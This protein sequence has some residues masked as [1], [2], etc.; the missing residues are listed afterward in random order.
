MQL[1]DDM[2]ARRKA[3]ASYLE[4]ARAVGC[5]KSTVHRA[6]ERAGTAVGKPALADPVRGKK[7]GRSLAEFRKTYDKDFIIPHKIKDGLRAL[8]QGWEYE[9]QFA[10]L[11]GVALSDLGNYRD[12]FTD[13]VVSM[14]DRRAWAGSAAVAKQMREML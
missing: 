5:A 3:G 14:R 4:I 10:H 8:G 11:I 7:S 2:K 9:V 13:F 12:Q 6:F 1:T